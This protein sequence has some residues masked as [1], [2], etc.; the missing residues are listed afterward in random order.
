MASEQFTA[1]WKGQDC[2]LGWWLL[3][4][5]SSIQPSFARRL[6]WTPGQQFAKPEGSTHG[7]AEVILCADLTAALYSVHPQ[8]P[9]G[10][11]DIFSRKMSAY[12]SLARTT[13]E[14]M[15]GGKDWGSTASWGALL[16]ASGVSL[17]GE[18]WPEAATL[19]EWNADIRPLLFAPKRG[20]RGGNNLR[21]GQG[22][23]QE[24]GST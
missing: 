9:E 12:T 17:R 11:M 14:N 16:Y 15:L 22:S 13:I 7:L 5:D 21:V 19:T 23:E 3:A 18:P 4:R 2:P 24:D 1:R 10:G 8:V 6:W 20:Q